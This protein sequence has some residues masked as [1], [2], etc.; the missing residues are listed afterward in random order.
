[1]QRQNGF[2]GPPFRQGEHADQDDA[3]DAEADDRCR[4]PSI[5]GAA[6]TREEHE[7]GRGQDQD[8]GPEVVD[9]VV[10]PAEMA[11][12]LAPDHEERDRPDRDVDVEDPPPREL[13]DED[14]SEQWADHARYAE[15]RAEVALVAAPISRRDDVPDDRLG[16]D[17]QPATAET[18]K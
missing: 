1:M 16:A 18:L 11:R 7:T 14:A 6:K 13:L 3:R 9:D 15:H 10:D 12:D 17:H 8:D 2:N 5:R 4:G